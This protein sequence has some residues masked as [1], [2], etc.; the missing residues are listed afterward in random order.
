M[1]QRYNYQIETVELLEK[2]SKQLGRIAKVLESSPPNGPSPPKKMF[3]ASDDDREPIQWR[4]VHV[5]ARGGETPIA[6]GKDAPYLDFRY[7]LPGGGFVRFDM[8]E[9]EE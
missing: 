7:P 3:T 8:L 2:M 1:G 5:N 6:T 4:L 9:G